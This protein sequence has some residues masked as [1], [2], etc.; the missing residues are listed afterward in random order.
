MTQPHPFEPASVPRGQAVRAWRRFAVM[1]DT[2]PVAYPMIVVAGMSDGPTAALVAG[3]HGDEYEGPAALWR[4]AAALRPDQLRGRVV[5]V[6][7]AHVAA[8]TAGTRT[9]PVDGANLARVFPGDAQGSLTQRLAHDLF[10]TVVAGADLLL[11]LHSGGVRLAFVPVAGFY[12]AADGVPA[13]AA[14]ASL[15]LARAAGMPYLWRLPPRPGVL[16]FEA[17]R[18]G[19]AA[20]G[21]EA[22]GRGGCD[23]SDVDAYVAAALRALAAHGM[24]D[25]PEGM[26]PAPEHRTALEGDWALAPAGGF[27]DPVA[28]L[29]A[30]VRAGDVLATLRDPFG[31][32]HVDL[33]AASE[34]IV[35]GVRHLRM[36]HAGEWAT[37]AVAEV[38]L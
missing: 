2:T 30:R 5:I 7:V 34:G 10:W 33:F 20:M 32:D 31:V 38:P 8:Y 28:P 35:M 9:S 18:H 6:P 25:P 37:C 19:I 15:A 29:G 23:P 16:T 27:L 11:D 36:I 4:V 12:A 3:I 24:I 21:A 22:G 14:A 17:A 1:P 13:Q 26:P